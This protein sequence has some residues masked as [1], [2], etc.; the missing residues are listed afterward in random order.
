MVPYVLRAVYNSAIWT[1]FF[2]S[3]KMLFYVYNVLRGWRIG[4]KPKFS[5][6]RIL[7]P[8]KALRL[9]SIFYGTLRF[10]GSIQ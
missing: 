8:L 4:F 6:M 7:E 2:L 10:K 3:G 1:L 9:L 5:E